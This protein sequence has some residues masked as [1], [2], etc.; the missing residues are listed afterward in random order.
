[1]KSLDWDDSGDGEV[2]PTPCETTACAGHVDGGCGCGRFQRE[3]EDTSGKIG[4][5]DRRLDESMPPLRLGTINLLLNQGERMRDLMMRVA[6]VELASGFQVHWVDGAG[7]IDPGKMMPHLRRVG[8]EPRCGLSRL[9]V[10]RAHTAYQLAGQIER[11][12][13][14][15]SGLHEQNRLFVIDN[16]SAMFSDPQLLT[17]ESVSLLNRA[18]ANLRTLAERGVCILISSS[19]PRQSTT[20][21]IL[22][23]SM[24]SRSDVVIHARMQHGRGEAVV[25]MV[26]QG[27]H[28]SVVTWLPPPASQSLLSD[29]KPNES[30]V[31]TR[32]LSPLRDIPSSSQPNGERIA[33]TARRASGS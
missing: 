17:S 24:T 29:F 1:M 32:L 12:V 23:R 13:G 21:S 3:T 30:R 4:W 5:S 28:R 9:K 8:C 26:C 15:G 6:V 16:L 18:M 27:E 31:S 25:Q 33:Q 14:A 7:R 11:L 22:E 20:H 19:R 10:S 2:V